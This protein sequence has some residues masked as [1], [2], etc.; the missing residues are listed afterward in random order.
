M[1]G[2]FRR[3]LG[4]RQT[5]EEAI[6]LLDELVQRGDLRG[7]ERQRRELSGRHAK[8][9]AHMSVV[10]EER[11]VLEDQMLASNPFERCRLLEHQSAR[12]AGLRGAQHFG[13]RLRREAIERQ[14][15]LGERVDERQADEQEA[16]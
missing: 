1:L 5:L 7:L 3:S 12:P 8:V 6:L 11:V 9:L 10:V 4:R 13:A 2:N 14:N 15:Q 16:Q